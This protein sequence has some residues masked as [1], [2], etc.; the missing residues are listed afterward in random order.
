MIP[1]TSTSFAYLFV[2]ISAHGLGHLAQVAPVLNALLARL[3]KL[4][5]TVRSD[6]P[7]ERLRTRI[8]ASMTHLPGSSDFGYVMHDATRVDLAAT[9]RAYRR[10]HAEWDRLVDREAALLAELR[11]DLVLTDV[12]Y[13]PLAG[14][15]RAQ[16]PSVA[17][18]SL[19]WAELFA[20]FFSGE[21]WAEAIHREMLAA[22]NSAELFM[23]LTPGM[24]MAGLRRL[25]S[26]PP[27]A[28][29]GRY[30]GRALRAKLACPA[31]ERLLL[32]AFG[33][34]GKRLPIENWLPCPKLRWLVPEAWRC[35]LPGVHALE[36]LGLSFTDLICSVDAVLTKPGYGTFTEAACNGTPVLYV[37]REN[38]PEQDSLIAWLRGH[39]RC[40][41]VE[42][43]ELHAESISG[44]V[45][46]LLRQ[47]KP[48][49]P[50][51]AGACE[52]AAILADR[53]N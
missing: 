51:A 43:S 45:E 37:R 29:L 31:D 44:V 7:S 26:I 14:A 39:A 8:L 18:C 1:P 5:L 25:R 40:R 4:R 48:P 52:A 50:S 28:T 15:Q 47:A 21:P 6:L 11:P 9:A 20:H 27:V 22:Y 34:V 19:N 53:L 36:S 35:D 46:E 24:A 30:Q 42:E 2:D 10:Q 32:V 41:G 38:W 49:V 17:M 16:I 13:L 12:A 23:R 3:P 33:G